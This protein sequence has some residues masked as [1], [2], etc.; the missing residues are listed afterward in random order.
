M[1][2]I[3]AALIALATGNAAMDMVAEALR[4]N[5]DF[6]Q[7]ALRFFEGGGASA[8]LVAIQFLVNIVV[9]AIFSTVGGLIGGAVFKVEPPMADNYQPPAPPPPTA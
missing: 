9:G 5:P 6:P 1:A 4:D 2:T 8:G 7:E 3:F